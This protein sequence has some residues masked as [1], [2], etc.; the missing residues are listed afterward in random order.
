MLAA[1]SCRRRYMWCP[2]RARGN[3]QVDADVQQLADEGAV[4]RAAFAWSLRS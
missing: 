1:L 3:G 2:A 4:G